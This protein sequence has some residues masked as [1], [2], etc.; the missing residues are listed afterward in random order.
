MDNK[1]EKK[2]CKEHFFYYYPKSKKYRCIYCQLI[3]KDK[4][5]LINSKVKIKFNR[6]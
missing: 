1:N 4:F 3:T 6:E 5:N 2:N